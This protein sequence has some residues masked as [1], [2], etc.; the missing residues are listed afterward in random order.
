M[1]DKIK[2][3][4]NY[5]DMYKNMNEG[6]L[7]SKDKKLLLDYITNLQQENERLKE[8]Q[9]YNNYCDEQLKKKIS[10]LEY[11]ITTLEDY[12]SR[13]KK[14]VKYIDTNFC[15]ENRRDLKEVVN[16]LQNGSEEK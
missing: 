5:L 14:A 4:L 16:I 13:C 10:N 6:L 12:K 11:K 15:I 2:E 1:N 9:E 8:E 3:I 7:N